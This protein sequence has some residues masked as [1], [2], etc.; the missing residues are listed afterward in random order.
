METPRFN[1]LKEPWTILS[2][3]VNTGQYKSER[4]IKT[5]SGCF[6]VGLI[7]LDNFL[8]ALYVYNEKR[9]YITC[10]VPVKVLICFWFNELGH[11][12]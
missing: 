11:Y 7:Y 10:F 6:S 8:Y 9:K 4:S 3:V 12:S 2:K 1:Q 5:L